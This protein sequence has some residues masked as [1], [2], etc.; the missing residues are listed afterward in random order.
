[1]R[2]KY[3]KVKKINNW[4]KVVKSYDYILCIKGIFWEK[5]IWSVVI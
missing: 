2:F 4:R 1:M 5:N 3:Y